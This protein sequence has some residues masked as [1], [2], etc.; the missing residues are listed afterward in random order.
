MHTEVD[1]RVSLKESCVYYCKRAIINIGLF[2][3][4]FWL[5]LTICTVLGLTIP[6]DSLE[7]FSHTDIV[8]LYF[9]LPLLWTLYRVFRVNKKYRIAHGYIYIGKAK[10]RL[11]YYDIEIKHPHVY[12]ELKTLIF[13]RQQS[14]MLQREHIHTQIDCTILSCEKFN[15]LAS[16]I[17]ENQR[18]MEYKPKVF[19][20]P[21]LDNIVFK[22]RAMAWRFVD[23]VEQEKLKR[24]AKILSV[25]F[26]LSV[27]IG[28]YY[29]QYA[30]MQEM[31]VLFVTGSVLLGGGAARAILKLVYKYQIP[32]DALIS[33]ELTEQMLVL[34]LLD[35]T[36]IFRTKRIQG[37][38]VSNYKYCCV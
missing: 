18:R 14:I 37:V 16:I 9:A 22:A 24:E 23:V 30:I 19:F 34:E 33:V 11:E 12:S 6:S 38:E 15:E 31:K 1:I 10:Y 17:K 28:C 27:I 13:G 8:M 4:F 32:D 29:F 26:I 35:R 21:D 2:T 20:A 7:R 25:I 5:T 36:F 3:C